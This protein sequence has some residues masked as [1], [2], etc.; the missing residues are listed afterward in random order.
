MKL[1]YLFLIILVGANGEE[2]P[3]R[4]HVLS[5]VFVK[6]VPDTV[7]IYEDTTPIF[8]KV[9]YAFTPP[10]NYFVQ[11]LRD[12]CPPD[13]GR[14]S[15]S[16]VCMMGPYLSENFGA[17]TNRL[18]T[19]YQSL[20]SLIPNIP[21]MDKISAIVA[22]NRRYPEYQ[23]VVINPVTTSD[24]SDLSSE[25]IKEYIP[26]T[27]PTTT[28]SAM[29][30]GDPSDPRNRFQFEHDQLVR[31]NLMA[32][33]PPIN[34]MQIHIPPSTT[35]LPPAP[36]VSSFVEEVA[37]FRNRN[38]DSLSRKGRSVMWATFH[39]T[40]ATRTKRQAA[41]AVLAIGWVGAKIY[42]YVD[43]PSDST[44]FS[45]IYEHLQANVDSNSRNAIRIAETIN[46]QNHMIGSGLL[47]ISS[48]LGTR[49]RQNNNKID[50]IQK[51]IQEGMLR[52]L[53]F[54]AHLAEDIYRS[55]EISQY[56]HIQSACIN[57]RLSP[58]AVDYD[59]LKRELSTLDTALQI[60]NMTMVIPQDQLSSYYHH[61]LTRCSFHPSNGL[62]QIQLDIPIKSKHDQVNI[63]EIFSVP[64]FH[65]T[66]LGEPQ[67]CFVKYSHD[68]V[69]LK[70]DMPL[71]ISMAD[72]SHCKISDGICQYFSLATRATSYAGCIK[73]L[74]APQG[75][76]FD[77]LH[78]A[79]PF[80]CRL[81]NSDE[82]LVTKL[83][84]HNSFYRYAI[85]HPPI[86]SVII[87]NNNSTRRTFDL[88]QPN[89]TSPY[90][91]IIVEIPCNCY[92]NLN[93][94]HPNIVPPFPCLV[95]HKNSNIFATPKLN[96]AIPSRWSL[97]NVA[98]IIQVNDFHQPLYLT[99]GYDNFSDIY[100]PSWFNKDI[101]L[102]FTHPDVQ[103][104]SIDHYVLAY[105]HLLTPATTT[106][107]LGFLSIFAIFLFY[108]NWL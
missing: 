50:E 12:H 40:N 87:Y 97:I 90:G 96:F 53:L 15:L 60:N 77:E 66:T 29:I 16:P 72:T 76:R 5:G 82:V 43:P 69:I 64:F 19:L 98:E 59:T 39:N 67:V 84:W 22:Q 108:K 85:T 32:N 31:C 101:V 70:N 45:K 106:I 54:H 57:G 93:S 89:T 91:V 18:N 7:I 62:I 88:L 33:R 105:H 3:S 103:T 86:N 61:T 27:K 99:E 37:R 94:V 41:L 13:F 47:N 23:P 63:A 25:V 65:E 2:L 78:E 26:T 80:S 10:Q 21:S 38:S 55:I 49:I 68:F 28:K 81:T 58:L 44:D 36:D 42:N 24:N 35:P 17:V 73:A 52:S 20:T 71:P 102:N 6:P 107:W 92:I 56:A 95:G 30:L 75:T 9:N 8:F 34:Q 83:G 104:N 1:F 74:L 11:D 48:Y 100:D 79:C 46:N 51:S 14:G 4:I